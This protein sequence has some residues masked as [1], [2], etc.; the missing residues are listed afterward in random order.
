M[1]ESDRL[2]KSNESIE[3]AIEKAK[4]GREESVI[5]EFNLIIF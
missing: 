3:Q 5:F 2:S 1:Q 4:V